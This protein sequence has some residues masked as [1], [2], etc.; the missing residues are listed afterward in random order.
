[1]EWYVGA[2]FPHNDLTS[3][4]LRK[5]DAMWRQ[6]KHALDFFE[7]HLP[8]YREMRPNTQVCSHKNILCFAKPGSTYALYIPGG[9][10]SSEQSIDFHP[11]AQKK[12]YAVFW[13]DPND[14]GELTAGTVTKIAPGT[15][16]VGHPRSDLGRDWVV[17]IRSE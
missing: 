4:D 6:T 2:K 14:G 10:M 1:M 9:T 7:R 13:Y 16:E 3:E 12:S 17:L 5:R 8:R 11:V 15:T